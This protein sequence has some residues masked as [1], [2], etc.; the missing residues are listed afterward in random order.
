MRAAS[1]GGSGGAGTP[2]QW[3]HSKV[4]ALGAGDRFD[5]A[6]AERGL[7]ALDGIPMPARNQE[8][9][10]YTDMQALLYGGSAGAGAG[11]TPA[12][13]L[14]VADVLEEAAEGEAGAWRL[15]FVNGVLSSDLSRGTAL[16]GTLVGGASA[17][18][19]QGAEL[20][21]RVHELLAALPELDLF[22]SPARDSLGTAKLAALNQASLQDVACICCA[23][24][25]E[26]G[27]GGAAKSPAVRVEVVF[28]TT[29]PPDACSSPRLL[30]DVGRHRRVHLTESHLSLDPADVSLS[31]GVSRVV[32]AEG[33]ELTH[34]YLQQKAGGARVVETLTAEV[35]AASRYSLRVV[36][37]GGRAARLNAL[38]GLFGEGGSC[39][40][41]ATMIAGEQQQLDLHSLIHHV[42]PGCES[43]QQHKNIVGGS[44][45]CVFKG[46]VRVDRDA[47]QTRSSQICR[48]L[49]LTKKAKVK[50]M[51]SLQIRAD[52]VSCSHGAAVT[53]LDR[54][55]LFYLGSRGLDRRTAGRLLLT[56]FPQDLL[57]GLSST[58]PRAYSRV[59]AKLDAVADA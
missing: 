29:G 52:D 14:A 53:E 9:W 49:L 12:A 31:N 34:E 46:S 28:L 23:P 42:A 35:A 1:A 37:T 39:E 22:Q 40:V 44:A 55:Q 41:N 59:L 16:P 57:T 25:E 50:A 20:L 43:K 21:G 19:A 15:V 7:A 56:A 26:G 27:G 51:P 2:E 24:E 33:A 10:R 38:V 36:A 54:E 32:L 4:A 18:A 30:V 58:A 45:E 13:E 17:L 48:S 5:S 8:A 3:L 11:Q 6:L 47:Q